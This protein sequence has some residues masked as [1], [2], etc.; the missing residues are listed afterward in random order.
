M[1]TEN[2]IKFVKVTPYD[3]HRISDRQIRV[4]LQDIQSYENS[5]RENC[6]YITIRNHGPQRILET[7]ESIDKQIEALQRDSV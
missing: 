5:D 2:E 4:N 7:A 6:G 3:G 1:S